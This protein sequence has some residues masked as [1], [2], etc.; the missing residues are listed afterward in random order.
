MHVEVVQAGTLQEM[1]PSTKYQV[2][3]KYG[4]EAPTLQDYENAGVT[5]ISNVDEINAFIVELTKEDV[6][7]T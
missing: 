7:T 6:D 5:G 3:H 1:M 2:M 4:G